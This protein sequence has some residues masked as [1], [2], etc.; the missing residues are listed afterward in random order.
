MLRLQ[1]TG[2]VLEVLDIL[3]IVY[4]CQEV[5]SGVFVIFV[6]E[7]EI[8]GFTVERLDSTFLLDILDLMSYL[9]A[10]TLPL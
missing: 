3:S 9:F 4:L 6:R 2:I 8:L 1:E 7:L 10:V 5:F